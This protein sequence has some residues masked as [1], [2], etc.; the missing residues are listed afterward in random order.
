MLL[1]DGHTFGMGLKY[2]ETTTHVPTPWE[3]EETLDYSLPN[4]TTLPNLTRPYTSDHA[5]HWENI[6]ISNY[7]RAYEAKASIKV[8]KKE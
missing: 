3:W 8:F 7:W 2:V 6:V 4:T 1:F 5:Q